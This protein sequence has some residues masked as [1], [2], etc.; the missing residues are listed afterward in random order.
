MDD[1]IDDVRERGDVAVCAALERFDGITV[2]PDGLRVSADEFERAQVSAEVD[3]A[4]DDVM[5]PTERLAAEQAR[6]E[7]QFRAD[8]AE[9]AERLRRT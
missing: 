8:L 1:L 7:I 4:I 6:Y 5:N 9:L 3:A 2:D